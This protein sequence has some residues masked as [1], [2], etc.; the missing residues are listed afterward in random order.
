MNDEYM[1]ELMNL[2]RYHGAESLPVDALRC[3]LVPLGKKLSNKKINI[4]NFT[5]IKKYSKASFLNYDVSSFSTR[6]A[7]Q[8]RISKV[9]KNP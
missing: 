5:N 6:S 2:N 1:T 3:I 9:W 7:M 8:T 4:V